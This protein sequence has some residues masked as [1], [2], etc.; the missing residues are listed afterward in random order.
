M[1]LSD[2][3]LLKVLNTLV[4]IVNLGAN[5]YTFSGEPGK[6]TFITPAA[7]AFYIWSLIHLLL[8]GYIIYQWTDAGKEVIIDNIGIRFALL[9]ALTSLYS[10]FGVRGW[11]ITA[12]IFSIL[13][14]ATVS[15]IYYTV[16]VNHRGGNVYDELFV[17][18]P[19]SLYHAWALVLVVLSGFQA[20]GRE[21]HHHAGVGTKVFV[22]LALF[23]LETSAVGY[24]FSSREGDLGGALTISWVLWAIF[25]HQTSSK[26]IHWSALVFAILATFFSV[27]ALFTTWRSG[28]VKA[29]LGDEERAP[30]L[31][32][33]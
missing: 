3:L 21:A 27:K 28:G 10:F 18:L 31:G 2:G 13:V 15:S 26:F 20:F 17:H 6:E 29:V 5:V 30:L 8:L 1:A 32:S 12:F 25:Q 9:G 24:A 11:Y 23:F 19:Y 7:Y 14:S 33:S 4:Y 22:F 16:R